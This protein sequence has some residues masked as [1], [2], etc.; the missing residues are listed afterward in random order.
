MVLGGIDWRW[1]G[2]KAGA[3]ALALW[4]LAI[5]VLGVANDTLGAD[6]V[7][8]SVEEFTTF[9]KRDMEKYEKVVRLSGAKVD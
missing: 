2:L 9:V 7:G 1:V 6:P 3:H 8:S 5:L 4:P